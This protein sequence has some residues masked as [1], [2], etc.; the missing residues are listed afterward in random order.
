MSVRTRNCQQRSALELAHIVFSSAS[1]RKRLTHGN[2]AYDNSPHDPF[3][4]LLMF[5]H[6]FRSVFSQGPRDSWRLMQ[7]ASAKPGALDRPFRF[8]SPGK[9]FPLEPNKNS[10]EKLL[11]N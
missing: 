1:V 6:V 2:L 7:P 11:P 5:L 3:V 9:N 4:S 8:F 10:K